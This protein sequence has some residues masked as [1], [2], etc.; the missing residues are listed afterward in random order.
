LGPFGLYDRLYQGFSDGARRELGSIISPAGD[1][2][3]Q[4][5]A[6]GTTRCV[7]PLTRA[8]A[9][10]SDG[11]C[12]QRAYYWPRQSYDSATTS[13]LVV[14]DVA[15]CQAT[16][17]TYGVTSDI[18]APTYYEQTPGGC[19]SRTAAAGSRLYT[20]VETATEYPDGTVVAGPRRGRLGYLY[21]VGPDGEAI[22]TRY[23]DHDLQLPCTPMNATDGRL[24]CL[25][26]KAALQTVYPDASCGGT[27][28]AL[29]A[30]CFPGTPVDGPGY[31]SCSDRYTVRGLP[32]VAAASVFGD[33]CT[34]L[35]GE[36]YDP[37]SPGGALAPS[38]FAELIE[39]I[40]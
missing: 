28:E 31:S 38:M 3:P 34:T 33:K 19:A 24:R 22:A 39:V 2:F 5:N 40:E 20:A 8:V 13:L 37:G 26:S 17:K 25:P 27:P 4:G 29:E 11:A 21:W 18:T 16:F 15:A 6:L 35:D 9:V 10:Y 1:C 23:Y 7:P 30:A 14:D 12:T 32:S 36:F